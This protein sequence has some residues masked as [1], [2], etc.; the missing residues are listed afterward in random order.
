MSATQTPTHHRVIIIGAGGGG[1]CMGI[2]LK[3]AGIDDF[4]M[5]DRAGGVGG[6]WYWNTYPGAECDVQSHLYSFSFE[7]KLDW[8]RPFAGQ[9]EILEYMNHCADKYGLRPHLRLNTP[10]GAARWDEAHARWDVETGDGNRLTADVVVS[11][12]GM[13]NNLVWPEIP[14]IDDFAGE[15]F[16]SA[17]WNHDYDLTGKRV[18]VVGI[19]ASAV[20]FVPEIVKKVEHVTLYQRT[21]NWV[22][23][24]PNTPY[25]QTELAHFRAHPEAVKA[26]RDEIYQ[27]WN[28]LCTF[29]DKAVLAE[30]E[31]QGLERIATVRDAETRAKLTPQHPFGCRRPLFSD[32]YYWIFNE[33]NVE[34]VTTPIDHVG[35][36]GVVTADG[37]CNEVDCLIYSTGFETTTYLNAI[38]VTGRDGVS[39]REAWAEEGAQ[40]YLGITTAGFPNLFM[41]YGP[42]T[43]QGCILFMIERQ[44]DYVVRQLQR[45]E[46]E[47]LAWI[48]VKPEVMH[49][50]N[51]EL[52]KALAAVD[53]W[54]AACGGE[55]YYRSK[56]GRMVT[57]WPHSMDAFVAATT[58]PDADAYLSQSAA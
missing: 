45:M 22:V 10:V 40:A 3:K 48:D 31:R 35:A 26:S 24:K 49:A 46:A 56:S 5:L 2:Q 25:E 23:P 41:L 34:L 18:G 50:F 58:R 39:L 9:A 28:T 15:Y 7:P 16:H 57:Q 30:I 51:D 27:T 33:P 4:I 44:V 36:R 1:L 38:E 13:F 12:L 11:A 55:F 52:Q 21:A 47:K 29:D 42:N 8:S 19:A 14:G 54:Q 37:A 43:N 17:R 53:V 32:N 6:T 20:Q